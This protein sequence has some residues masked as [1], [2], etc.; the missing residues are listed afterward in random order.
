VAYKSTDFKGHIDLFFT[1]EKSI[2]MKKIES[3]EELKK[4]A[5]NANGDYSDFFIALNFGARSSKR[6]SYDS[7]NK[8][9]NVIN[10]IDYS[11]QD[12]L[13]EEQLREETHI[14]FAIE[15]GAF[16]KYYF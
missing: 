12:D 1:F 6:V 5:T 4:E 10:E 8:T 7:E 2:I 15:N 9:F 14:V 3:I 16:Y 13:T 11:Y